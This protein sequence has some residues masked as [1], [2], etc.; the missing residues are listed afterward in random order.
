MNSKRKNFFGQVQT[1]IDK[2]TRIFS[3]LIFVI[4]AAVTVQIV[5]RYGFN[6]FIKEIVPLIQQS[7][8][9]F[10]L[11][12]GLYISSKGGHI[13]VTVF[14]DLFGPRMK[15]FSKVLSLICMSIF[16]GILI[17]QSLWMGLNALKHKETMNGIY[18]FMPMYPLKL[19]I[20]VAVSFILI[21]GV[22]HFFKTWHTDD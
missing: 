19:F 16:L 13:R 7:F 4:V 9:V 18:K 6:N 20:P 12:G 3:F 2:I 5:S 14:Y 15:R 10:L 22:I 11:I 1:F 8:A 21:V 17:W